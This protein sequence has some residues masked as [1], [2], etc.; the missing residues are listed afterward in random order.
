MVSCLKNVCRLL[1]EVGADMLRDRGISVFS[2]R[3]N[4]QG[5]GEQ[6]Q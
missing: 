2:K 3:S 6:T 4:S 1:L 5:G